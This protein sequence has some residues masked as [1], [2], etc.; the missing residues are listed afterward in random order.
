MQV[1]SLNTQTQSVLLHFHQMGSTLS[2]GF[3]TRQFV[4]GMLPQE[5][6]LQVH[7]LDTQIQF[8]LLHF[9]Q[10]G[11]TLSLGLMTGQFVSGMLPQER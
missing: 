7:P 4:P 1:H 8:V 5:K 6:E 3:M 11:I 2:Q 9:H 10:I